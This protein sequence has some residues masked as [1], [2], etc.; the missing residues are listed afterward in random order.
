MPRSARIWPSSYAAFS[1]LYREAIRNPVVVFNDSNANG[2]ASVVAHV[3]FWS[4][5]QLRW[6]WASSTIRSERNRAA[7]NPCGFFLTQQLSGMGD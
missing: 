3:L 6:S 5:A 2:M 7:G 1:G 4:E